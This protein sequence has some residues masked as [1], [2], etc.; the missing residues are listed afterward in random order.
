VNV[1]ANGLPETSNQTDPGKVLKAKQLLAEAY[2]GR[3]RAWHMVESE[4]RHSLNNNRPGTEFP[5]MKACLLSGLQSARPADH[6]PFS[7][8]AHLLSA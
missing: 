3:N 7:R 2:D 1:L 8:R 5:C 6:R 4:N